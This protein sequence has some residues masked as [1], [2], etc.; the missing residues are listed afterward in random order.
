MGEVYRAYDTRLRRKVAI[1]T[2]GSALLADPAM[3]VR[4]D[5][6]A[7]AIAALSHPNILAI[8][9][10]G[11]RD[12]IPFIAV[13]LLEGDTLRSRIGSSPLALATALDYG[14]QIGRGLA[15]AH[16]RGIIHRDL[17]PENVFVTHDGLVKL[18]DF[19]LAKEPVTAATAATTQLAA[20]G[21]GMVL[22]TAAYMSPEQARGEPV[23]ARSDI[24]A[25]GCVLYEML[26]G[27]R[28]FAGDSQIET[29]HAVLKEH[30]PDLGTLRGDLPPSFGRV[31][32]RCLEKA[33]ESRFQTARDL[34]FAL[35]DPTPGLAPTPLPHPR[36]RSAIAIV[37]A[38]ALL[39]AGAA[40]WR[41]GLRE[42][43]AQAPGRQTAGSVDRSR[44][45]AVLP[46]ENI[47][48]GDEDYF[49]QGM[50]REVT[51][52]LSKLSA[53]RVISS[54]AVAR[55]AVR[56]DLRGGQIL[57]LARMSTFR[58]AAKRGQQCK[59]QDLTPTTTSAG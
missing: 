29:L 8:Y 14:V 20:T 26:A 58:H 57:F 3:R 6:E 1:K 43:P 21:A 55:S 11:D 13:E 23:D 42:P 48:G 27:R 39:A 51:S 28:A 59:K 33:P 16:D 50:T 47:S 34:V 30:P 35:E 9:D 22:G 52:Q 44:V 41:I 2:V 38:V 36:R 56:K 4:F 10:V 54:S 17:K 46:F 15:A 37:A 49:A 40:A 19:G 53:L 24:F 32:R 45:L 12:G 7:R 25:L 18:L 5:R 31:V